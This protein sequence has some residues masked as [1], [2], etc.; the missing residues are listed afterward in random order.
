MASSST[1]YRRRRGGGRTAV[2]GYVLIGIGSGSA[3]AAAPIALSTG[4]GGV[5]RFG[6]ADP[7]R[8]DRE[9]R[10]GS[11]RGDGGPVPGGSV[12]GG[13]GKPAECRTRDPAH[14]SVAA[15]ESLGTTAGR[16][17]V[18]SEDDGN[19]G[20]VLGGSEL[21]LSR[22][23]YHCRWTWVRRQ[24]DPRTS[25][26]STPTF[27]PSG[28]SPTPCHFPRQATRG[29]P[30]GADV[31]RQHR[32]RPE[33]LSRRRSPSTRTSRRRRPIRAASRAVAGWVEGGKVFAWTAEFGGDSLVA[34][35]PQHRPGAR[36]TLAEKMRPRVLARPHACPSAQAY[37]LLS[38]NWTTLLTS[39]GFCPGQRGLV[40]TASA[41]VLNRQAKLRR[42]RRRR[43]GE[44]GV[45]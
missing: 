6:R 43:E 19:G 38:R 9:R 39:R 30:A 45:S 21:T 8:L 5:L 1:G 41:T 3:A 10:P 27:R 28:A 35:R 31:E 42:Q 7:P 20:R 33:V 44:A 14:V 24:A 29:N 25:P 18:W 26:N 13:S 34:R 17:L 32:H 12:D 40:R 36:G 22:G 2:R 4:R 37:R 16:S 11:G 23:G 15:T